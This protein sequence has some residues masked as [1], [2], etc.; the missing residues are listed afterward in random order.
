MIDNG[1]IA[2]GEMK[3]YG[4]VFALFISDDV[5]GALDVVRVIADE[6]DLYRKTR[7]G[8]INSSAAD[9]HDQAYRFLHRKVL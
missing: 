5:I 8:A 7:V 2:A 6:D 3:P 4:S 1:L 9:V